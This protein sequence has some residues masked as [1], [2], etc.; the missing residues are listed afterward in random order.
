MGIRQTYIKGFTAGVHVHAI[1]D[2]STI[3]PI[4]LGADPLFHLGDR[5]GHLMRMLVQTE[6]TALYAIFP[7]HI[8]FFAYETPAN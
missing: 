7:R 1:T 4:Y 8:V 3:R 2:D 5:S 6:Q